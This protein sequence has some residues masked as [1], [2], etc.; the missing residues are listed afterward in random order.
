MI[1]KI[2]AYYCFPQKKYAQ[3]VKR[4]SAAKRITIRFFV[5]KNYDVPYVAK[6]F[7]LAFLKSSVR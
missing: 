7:A 5:V 4:I 2:I 3:K 1:A 6:L